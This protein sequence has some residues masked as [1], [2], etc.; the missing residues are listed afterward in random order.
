MKRRVLFIAIITALVIIG[1]SEAKV[2]QGIGQQTIEKVAKIAALLDVDEAKALE[3]LTAE[4][5]S[6]EK[7]KE[8]MAAIALDAKL[9][10]TFLQFKKTYTEQYAK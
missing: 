8:I 4:K 2:E 6:V 1:C 10:D 3:M 7:Y 5:M 9:T